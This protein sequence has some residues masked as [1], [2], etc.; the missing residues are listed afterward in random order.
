MARNPKH[1]KTRRQR[2]EAKS[3]R[4]LA[5]SLPQ[6]FELPDDSLTR[7]DV[8]V[9]N[10][11]CASGLPGMGLDRFDRRLD[12]LDEAARLVEL[13]TGRNY[14]KFLNDPAAYDFSQARYC[15]VALVTVLQQQCGVTYN[16]KWKG[17]TPGQPVPESFGVDASDLFIH[18]II[19]GIGGT[20]G[21]LPVLYVAVGRRLGY[22]LRIVKAA[23][24]LFVRWDDPDGKRWHHADRF[25]IEATGPG[26]HFLSD[27]H[28]R[29][30]P[31]PVSDDDVEAGIFLK[32]LTPREELA[33][34]VATRGYCLQA[35]RQLN[36]AIR[37]FG[38]AVRLVP[39][40]RHFAAAQ[41]SLRMQVAMSRR[42]HAYIND[43]VGGVD[44][45]SVGPFWL[46][47]VGSD[48]V[49]VQIVSPV[50]QPYS[51]PLAVSRHLIQRTLQTPSGSTVK[52]WLLTHEPSAEMTAHWVRLSDGRWA[53]VHK[54]A[55]DTWGQPVSPYQKQNAWHE[56]RHGP[57]LPEDDARFGGSWHHSMHGH[58]R[59]S[60][61]MHELTNLATRIEQ[62]MRRAGPELSLPSPPPLQPLALPAG[63]GIPPLSNTSRGIHYLVH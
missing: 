38:E 2:P 24:H 50:R 47:G 3:S 41:F 33:E 32:S 22:P 17:V 58:Q 18:A 31:H 30:W 35:N 59:E 21:S 26:I 57:I 53:L 42:G 51:P 39:H 43:V 46:N 16:R 34:F 13:E 23:R 49:L 45:K 44:Q 4:P 12:W 15:M 7:L 20:C 8:A 55:T 29:S 40:N 27:E 25:N 37:A 61:P 56:P 11:A 28:Y 6:L 1:Q 60:L 14:Y 63:P 19:D 36:E 52:V 48:K 54:T 62:A 9:A 5:P 10:L